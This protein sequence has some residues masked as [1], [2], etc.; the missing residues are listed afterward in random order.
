MCSL[1]FVVI[2]SEILSGATLESALETAAEN[3]DCQSDV[4]N[5]QLEAKIALLEAQ[6]GM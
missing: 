1:Y 5:E 4:T 2:F 6:L 3:D